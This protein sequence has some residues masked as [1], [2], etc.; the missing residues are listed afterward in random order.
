MEMSVYTRS[1][2]AWMPFTAKDLADMSPNSNIMGVT[3][4]QLSLGRLEKANI[5]R[6][7]RKQ[8]IRRFATYEV[9]PEFIDRLTEIVD[10]RNE[11]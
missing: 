11:L 4:W 6:M 1:A 3:Y 5:V 9:A 10:Q 8:G 2:G 7:T